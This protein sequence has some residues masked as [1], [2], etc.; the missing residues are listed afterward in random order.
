MGRIDLGGAAALDQRF[1]R[2]GGLY[3]PQ[4]R[5]GTLHAAVLFHGTREYPLLVLLRVRAVVR[6]AVPRLHGRRASRERMIWRS[7]EA[8]HCRTLGCAFDYCRA[9]LASDGLDS[10]FWWSQSRNLV[11]LLSPIPTGTE[12]RRRATEHSLFYLLVPPGRKRGEDAAYFR[13][14]SY[15]LT[16]ATASRSALSASTL[17][18][19]R[20][21]LFSLLM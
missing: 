13:A 8:L 17:S 18:I 9:R 16:A 5:S 20:C 12:R 4:L 21:S 7:V 6:E 1:S 3:R 19:S 10:R 11:P 2:A 15:S 14:R